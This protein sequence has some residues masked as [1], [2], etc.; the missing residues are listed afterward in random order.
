MAQQSASAVDAG[1]RDSLVRVD[2]HQDDG[3]A[4]KIEH[5]CRDEQKSFH[6]HAPFAP[7]ARCHG[8]GRLDVTGVT[9]YLFLAGW[10]EITPRM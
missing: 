1:A 9:E 2:R 8:R 5:Q 3:D 10:P 4:G 6:G 7:I